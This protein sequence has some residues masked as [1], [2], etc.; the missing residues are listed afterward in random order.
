MLRALEYG[1]QIR[2]VETTS[3]TVGVDT[4]EDLE[5]ATILMKKD[6]LFASYFEKT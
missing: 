5:R 6:S 3:E 2:M 1:Y 4:P